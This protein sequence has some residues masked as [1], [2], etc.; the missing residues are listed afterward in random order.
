[1][2]TF[3]LEVFIGRH[4]PEQKAVIKCHDT[5]V[6]LNVFLKT[7]RRTS[8]WRT[9]DEDYMIPEGTTA[10]L[11]VNKP[12]N[13]KVLQDGECQGSC[14]H[15]ELPTQTFAAAGTASAEVN[16]YGADGRRITTETFHID[17]PKEV[18]DDC[19]EDSKTYVS[20]MAAKIQAAIDAADRAE[21]AAARAENAGGGG[22]VPGAIDPEA[23]KGAVDEY[24][25]ENPPAQGEPG[26]DGQ[27]GYTPQK[28][29]DY[30]TLDE[31]QEVAEQ[32]AQMV[33]VPTGEDRVRLA[34]FTAEEDVSSPVIPLAD[35]PCNYKS[36]LIYATIKC[37]GQVWI[38]MTKRQNTGDFVTIV[39]QNT[40]LS[41]SSFKTLVCKIDFYHSYFFSTYT[42]LQPY[43]WQT[44]GQYTY[45]KNFDRT[46]IFD[47]LK[48]ECKIYTES[49][50]IVEGVK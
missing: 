3:D 35:N 47:A 12:D 11:K 30:F 39:H 22:N 45:S 6:R 41:D 7:E 1:M 44:S 17:V 10:V 8:K 4:K 50:I 23:I 14:V 40:H 27:D 24:L 37:G 43:Q 16:L 21:K 31:I 33:E 28:G 25:A 26:K 36:M 42:V 49:R 20:V 15:F 34:D 32:A 13:T 48:L 18:A 9:E 38:S 5:G 46:K 29:I 19:D 2:I